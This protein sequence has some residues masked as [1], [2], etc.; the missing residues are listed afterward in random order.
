MYICDQ[1]NTYFIDVGPSLSAQL[2]NNTNANPTQYT[3]RTLLKSFIFRPIY[4]HEVYDIIGNLKN[5]KSTIGSP[6]RYVKFAC[7]Y[8]FI[9]ALTKV[10]NQS[11]DLGIVPD[12]LKVS[13][14]TPIDKGD[15]ITDATNFQPILTLS[16]FAQ[17]FGK[18]VYKQLISFIEKYDILCRYQFG[19]TEGRGGPQS[20]Q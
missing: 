16:A 13:K 11:L 10:Y 4:E 9:K 6:I 15:D 19:F 7:N 17:I 18:L 20:K 14:V 2:P 1:L 5:N 12:I 3:H 8:I